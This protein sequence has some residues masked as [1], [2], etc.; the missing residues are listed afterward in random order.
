MILDKTLW[1]KAMVIVCRPKDFP[2]MNKIRWSRSIGEID[3]LF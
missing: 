1:V 2:K 3:G